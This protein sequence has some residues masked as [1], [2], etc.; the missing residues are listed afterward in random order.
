MENEKPKNT[1]NSEKKLISV[2][3]NPTRERQ[4]ISAQTSP[5]TSNHTNKLY[6]PT[7]FNNLLTDA[8]DTI[9]KMREVISEYNTQLDQLY[10]PKIQNINK[11]FQEKLQN[12][13]PSMIQHKTDNKKLFFQTK[14]ETL[15]NEVKM[16][17]ELI[18]SIFQK[19]D[20]P[21][22]ECEN[23]L[24]RLLRERQNIKSINKNVEGYENLLTTNEQNINPYYKNLIKDLIFDPK[25]KSKT[26]KKNFRLLN[27][28]N[29]S[30]CTC[31]PIEEYYR[32]AGC[33][34]INYAGRILVISCPNDN[35]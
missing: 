5:K 4:N 1:Y 15:S 26:E 34:Y 2:L 20:D 24:C 35:N 17:N 8:S 11:E 33:S 27:N 18:R 10:K 29:Q 21:N 7:F 3:K 19:L 16:L 28:N 22:Y 12:Y 9:N 30:V 14:N 23:E 31:T 13:S 6:P 32:Q 25:G